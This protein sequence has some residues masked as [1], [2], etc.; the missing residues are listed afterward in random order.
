M[1]KPDGFQPNIGVEGR[2]KRAVSGVV[3]L[4]VGVAFTVW[5]VRVGAPLW[6]RAILFMPFLLGVM[7]L[8]QA[9]GG[10]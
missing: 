7:G 3:F 8:V 5:A 6:M 9:A 4:L 1:A 10:T 2:V